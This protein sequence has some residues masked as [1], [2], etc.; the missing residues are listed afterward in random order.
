[1][2]F[3]SFKQATD[4]R[5][6]NFDFL[7]FFLASLVILSHS[8]PLVLGDNREEPLQRLTRGQT[9]FGGVAVAFFFVISGFLITHSWLHSRSP[10]DYLKKRVLR[11]YPGWTA[12]LLFG[13]LIVGPL[14]GGHFFSYV[15]QFG[16]YEYFKPLLLHSG[17]DR[18]PGVFAHN[19]FAGVVNGSLWTIRYEFLCYLMVAAL[20][21][22]GLY[23]SR[24]WVLALFVA[25]LLYESVPAIPRLNLNLRYFG[26]MESLPSLLSFYLAGMT[27]Y[28][29]RDVI[30]RSRLLFAGSLLLLA[31]SVIPSQLALALPIC[32]T[33]ALL[34]AAVSST[35]NLHEFG[36]R[37][38]ISYGIYLYAF[39]VQQMLIQGLPAA[40]HPVVLF[41]IAWPLTCLLAALSWHLVEKPFL[42]L[43]PKKV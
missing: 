21:L 18:L 10:L 16:T 42:R 34:Y 7:R 6:N 41:L 38:D 3:I 11:I 23:R 40:R 37:R 24:L 31:L 13:F 15:R 9:T 4:V 1:M 27:F 17:S 35:F 5:R 33:Y 12:A 32:G 19:P 14:S 43:K 26:P 29:F 8:Y 39:P 20:G 28:F 36:R 25:S 2:P 22:L 30:P